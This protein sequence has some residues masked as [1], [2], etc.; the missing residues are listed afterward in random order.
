MKKL[1][2]KFH[3]RGFEIVYLNLDDDREK[4]LKSI[5]EHDLTWI[6]VSEGVKFKASK[7]K[8]QF[9]VNT[10]PSAILVDNNGLIAN[11]AIDK[12]IDLS[13]INALLEK[14]FLAN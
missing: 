6:N 5:K 1:Y 10:I 8:N 14:I 12:S 4:W 3:A 13:L 11:L 9:L 7:I 2:K